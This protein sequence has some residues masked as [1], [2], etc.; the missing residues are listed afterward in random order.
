MS[1]KT[2][3]ITNKFPDRSNPFSTPQGYFESFPNWILDRIEEE[4][5]VK[6]KVSIIRYLK[7]ALAF[8]ASFA[9]IFILVYFSVKTVEPNVAKNDNSTELNQDLLPYIVT[10]EVLIKS[11][12]SQ[13]EE[14]IDDTV[15]E[16]VLLASVSDMELMNM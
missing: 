7:P 1:K 11:F 10:D 2:K 14:E 8:A 3:H 5:Q 15:I 4:N 12:Y 13:S 9:I 16:T 6:T